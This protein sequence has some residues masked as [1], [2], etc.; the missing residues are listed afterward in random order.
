MILYHRLIVL[1]YVIYLKY[2]MLTS[3]RDEHGDEVFDETWKTK[4]IK[5][6]AFYIRNHKFNEWDRR[7]YRNKTNRNTFG[8]YTKFPEPSLRSLH[9]EVHENCYNDFYKCISYIHKVIE[10]AP[11]KRRDDTVTILNNNSTLVDLNL[12]NKLDQDCKKILF[13]ADKTGLPFD[14]P[15]ERFI[16]RVSVSYF[17]CWYTMRGIADLSILGEPCD[18]FANCLDPKF[19]KNLISLKT[20]Y[21]ASLFKKRIKYLMASS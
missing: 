3:S 4:A 6:I 1:L 10:V 20:Y 19:V 14:G 18:N 21:C 13:Y 15:Q 11:F 2:I 17:M 7:F 8:F 5:D 9:W 16:W 12:I